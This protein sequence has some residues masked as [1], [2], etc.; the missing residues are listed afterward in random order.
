MA[1]MR[2]IAQHACGVGRCFVVL[3]ECI[4]QAGVGIHTHVGVGQPGKLLHVGP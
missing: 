3:T 4:G 2:E 1:V